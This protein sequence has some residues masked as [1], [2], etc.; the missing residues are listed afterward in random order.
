MNHDGLSNLEYQLI[1]V[2]KTRLYTKLLVKYN[3]PT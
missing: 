1:K 2:E 3:Q